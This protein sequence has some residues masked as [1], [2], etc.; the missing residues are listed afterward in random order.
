MLLP[1]P[2]DWEPVLL[3]LL[4]SLPDGW[5]L[6]L[7]T[8]WPDVD[9]VHVLLQAAVHVCM[10]RNELCCGPPATETASAWWRLAKPRLQGGF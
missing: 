3:L 9:G 8:V 10:A 5:L 4:E 7:G 6:L 1:L 2:L